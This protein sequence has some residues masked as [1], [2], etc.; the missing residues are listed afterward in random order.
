[1]D[2]AIFRGSSGAGG[3]SPSTDFEKRN[4]Y[5][6]RSVYEGTPWMGFD[7]KQAS[8][9]GYQQNTYEILDG[10]GQLFNVGGVVYG[11]AEKGIQALRETNGATKIGR[12]LGFGTQQT[13]KALK[14]TLGAISKF[15]KGLG[16]VGYGLQVTATGAKLY[17]GEKVGT[18]EAVGLGL[19]TAL[20][21]VAYIAAGTAAAPLVATGALIYGALELGSY[22]FT[23]K[24]V[25]DHIFEK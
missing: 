18:A 14:G 24:T 3:A 22:M 25:E 2:Y 10:F 19:S 21:G 8:S 17:N 15:G 12:E 1:M 11:G 23:G 16:V 6:T 5:N 20:I 7:I 13:A 9:A 4:W